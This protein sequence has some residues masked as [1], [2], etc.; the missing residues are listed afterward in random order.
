M[1]I[2]HILTQIIN[3]PLFI[4]PD[5]LQILLGILLPRHSEQLRLPDL[6]ALV[7]LNGGISAAA[8]QASVRSPNQSDEQSIAVISGTGSL[9]NRNYGFDGASGMTNYRDICGQ[10]QRCLVDQ[11]IGGMIIDFDTFGGQAAGCERAARFIQQA[12][13]HKPIYACIDL[14]AFSAGY[15]LAAACSRVILTDQSAGVGSVGCIA[16][17]RDQSQR[18]EKE[19]DVYTAVFFGEQKNDF[20]PHQPL[21]ESMKA[22]LQAGVNRLGMTFAK[23]VADFRGMELNAVLETKAGTVYGRDAITTGLADDIASFD[24]AVAML[25]EDIRK[26]NRNTTGGSVMTTKE[27]IAALLHNDDGPSALAELGYVQAEQA[28]NNAFAKGK[29]EGLSEAA[30]SIKHEQ[31]AVADLAELANLDA[32]C[33]LKLMRAGA[34]VE[35]ARHAIQE[36]KAR[37]TKQTIVLS[38]PNVTNPGTEKHGLISACEAIGK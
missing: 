9:V 10:I 6:S 38:T 24:E 37:T 5:K 12:A 22:K 26:K 11:S 32:A 4:A 31:A 27:R 14:N 18:N 7:A 30:T 29:E 8:E 3:T 36:M 35:E 13:E 20:S 19:G 16:I 21:T 25:A 1:S 2:H 15:Y 33:C 23:S 34:T 28:A 17:H